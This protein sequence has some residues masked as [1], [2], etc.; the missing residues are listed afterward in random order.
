MNLKEFGF[1]LN[2]NYPIAAE[3]G[4]SIETEYSEQ[5]GLLEDVSQKLTE[6]RGYL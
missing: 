6:L 3:V 4:L 5:K 2:S 1:T